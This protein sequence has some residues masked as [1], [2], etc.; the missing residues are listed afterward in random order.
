MTGS[1]AVPSLCAKC[2]MPIGNNSLLI[3]DRL[4]HHECSPYPA[5]NRRASSRAEPTVK[6]GVQVKGLAWVERSG[7]WYADRYHIWISSGYY[8]VSGWDRGTNPYETLEAAKA[9]AQ[10]DYE[11]RILSALATPS[12][13]VGDDLE[14]IRERARNNGR[15]LGEVLAVIHRDGGHYQAL[16]GDE[17]A[18]ADAME[19]VAALRTENESLKGERDLF[20]EQARIECDAKV[21]AKYEAERFIVKT[22]RAEAKL[23]EARK[24][25]KPFGG[26][27]FEFDGLE[28][29]MFCKPSVQI[30]HLRAARSLSEESSNG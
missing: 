7:G 10:D 28:D 2:S 20:K 24:A 12:L 17:K 27:A 16:H 30:K 8:I 22:D 23:E 21:A 6:A 9:A 14:P 25:L 11:A 13:P 3:G 26:R 19:A 15:W 5:W 1:S 4:Y 18:V 29:D